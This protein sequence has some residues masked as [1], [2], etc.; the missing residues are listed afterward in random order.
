MGKR[1]HPYR[2][3]HGFSPRKRA[4][5]ETPKV[6]RWPVSNNEHPKIQGFVGYKV[7][8]THGFVVDYRKRSTTSGQEVAIPITVIETPPMVVCGIRLY[9]DTEYGL[10]SIGEA[11]AETLDKQLQRTISIPTNNK[12]EEMGNIFDNDADDVRLIAHTKPI[13]ITG[14]PK[15]RPNIVEL[16]IGGATMEKRI[17]Y[18][19]G[20]LGKEIHV[21]EFTNEGAMLD[22]LAVT[23]GKGFQGHVKR[24]GV[25]LL[26]HK[27]SKHR[28]MIGTLGPWHPPYVMSTVPQAGQMGYHQRTEY[29]KR[30]LKIGKNPDDINPKGGFL[31]YGLV[32][33]D[34]VLFHGSIPGPTKRLIRLR[35]TIRFKGDMTSKVELSYISTQ[36]KQGA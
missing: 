16:R 24:F 33:N 31:H 34:Y 6:R 11:W 30:V 17:E 20:L 19:K 2:G 22:V 36:S 28:R 4:K 13:V 18:A 12:K 15:K 10:Q 23:K 35:D 32:R 27:N 9:K 25:K 14:I 7:G 5:K 8:M 29:N 1:H 26:S 3:S 21:N